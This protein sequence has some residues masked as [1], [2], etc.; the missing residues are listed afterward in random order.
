MFFSLLLG[1][2]ETNIHLE[3]PFLRTKTWKYG[4]IVSIIPTNKDTHIFITDAKLV[5]TS[6]I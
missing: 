3:E 6:I 4:G 2:F 5:L 1:K